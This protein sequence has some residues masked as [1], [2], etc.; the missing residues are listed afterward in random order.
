[1]DT[2]EWSNTPLTRPL[3][4]KLPGVHYYRDNDG[5]PLS[6]L[7]AVVCYPDSA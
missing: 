5:G 1:M 3:A 6:G 2:D 4:R 7:P